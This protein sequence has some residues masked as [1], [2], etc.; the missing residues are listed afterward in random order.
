M[1]YQ[2]VTLATLRTR[3]QNRYGNVAFW[4]NEEARLALN[5]ALRYWNLFTGRWRTRI[6][7]A[8]TAALSSS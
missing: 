8:T 4:S 6:V 3:L 5:E 1:P 2:A 7:L